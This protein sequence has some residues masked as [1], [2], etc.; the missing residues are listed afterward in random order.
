[1]AAFRYN[2]PREVADAKDRETA[3]LLRHQPV[4]P[5]MASIRLSLY[6]DDDINSKA[7]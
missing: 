2:I 5:A 1:M 3:N 7:V 6:E 4:V